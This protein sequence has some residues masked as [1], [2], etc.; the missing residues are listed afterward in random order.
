MNRSQSFLLD[1]L[2]RLQP[3][4]RANLVVP[5]IIPLAIL[6]HGHR[7]PSI[8]ILKPHHEIIIPIIRGKKSTKTLPQVLSVITP[9]TFLAILL[10]NG[11]LTYS[12][13]VPSGRI[14][15]NSSPR[16]EQTYG[17]YI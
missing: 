7:H 2:K 6:G 8:G 11:S 1:C 10:P 13:S 15:L 17:G 12:T 9:S 5:Q 16:E 3:P 4:Q 14:T